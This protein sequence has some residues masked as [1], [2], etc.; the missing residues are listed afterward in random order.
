[1]LYQLS[2]RRNERVC[3]HFDRCYLRAPTSAVSERPGGCG[4]VGGWVWVGVGVRG[5]ARVGVGVRG[6]ALSVRRS[7]GA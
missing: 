5:A 7:A 3:V 4:L 6:A 1:M 2:Y